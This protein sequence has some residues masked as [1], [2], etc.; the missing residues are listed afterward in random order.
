MKERERENNSHQW[1]V[2][3][4]ILRYTCPTGMTYPVSRVGSC[5]RVPPQLSALQVTTQTLQGTTDIIYNS[6]RPGLF[7]ASEPK[8][9]PDPAWLCSY[10]KWNISS[11]HFWL[12]SYFLPKE[13]LYLGRILQESTCSFGELLGKW[14]KSFSTELYTSV[15]Q[16]FFHNIGSMQ[17]R[18]TYWAQ[19][20]C[21][22]RTILLTELK[23]FSNKEHS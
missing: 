3:L 2:V 15:N 1:K 4:A 5:V 8:V 14:H 10:T 17:H 23:Q 22:H 21:E 12:F 18:C 6:K 9:S 16:S 11:S 7:N 20:Y 13:H 19:T